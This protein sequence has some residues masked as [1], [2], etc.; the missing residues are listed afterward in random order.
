MPT[1]AQQ[2]LACNG[3]RNQCRPWWEC[4]VKT[5]AHAAHVCCLS[6]RKLNALDVK[7]HQR[8]LELLQQRRDQQTTAGSLQALPKVTATNSTTSKGKG[9]RQD[10]HLAS[11]SSLCVDGSMACRM[12][13]DW[14]LA[15][16]W[17]LSL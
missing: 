14:Q 2:L 10:M 1:E 9:E 15:W 3:W 17:N 16:V 11:S 13:V 7:L 8:S 4:D 5:L 12:L 6:C